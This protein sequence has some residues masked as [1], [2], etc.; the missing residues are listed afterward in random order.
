MNLAPIAAELLSK[1]LG[2]SR[3]LLLDSVIVR[4]LDLALANVQPEQRESM[5]GRLLAEESEEWQR[6]VDEAVVPE[7]W[8]YRHVE[9]F[10][11]LARYVSEKW[12]PADGTTLFRALCI[13]CASGEEAYSVGMTLLNTG[14]DASRIR[15]DA[16][17]ISA[18]LLA[19]ARLGVYG[20]T[21][22][23]EKHTCFREKYFVN[24]EQGWRVREDIVRLVRFEKTNLLNLSRFLQRAPY[25]A[26]FCRNALIYL[27][28][29]ARHEV[30]RRMRELLNADGLLFTGSSEL[31]E[32]CAGGYV[33]VDYPQ[34][35]ACRKAKLD[36]ALAPSR[37]AIE[38]ARSGQGAT[39]T[40]HAATPHADRS[41]DPPAVSGPSTTFEQAERLADEGD[42]DTAASMCERLLEQNTADPK[43]YALLGVISESKGRVEPA[44]EFFRKALYLAPYHYE[45][46]LH[47]SL[48]C[49][50]RGDVDAAELYRA[51]AGRAL[52]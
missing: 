28:E 15:I 45:S 32:F 24:C 36:K 22:F 44:E 14:L 40:P 48:L 37:A 13:P 2:L 10:Q 9:S 35:F 17:D 4:A 26:I 1:R 6:L 38:V 19:R 46:L 49:E 21:S 11:F 31:A 5:A 3:E 8:F 25:D 30:I 7:T 52:N 16:A 50:R 41:V 23:R 27:N 42:L 20:E 33:P 34:S 47:M 12:R 51:R 29:S 39:T 43:V 18:R